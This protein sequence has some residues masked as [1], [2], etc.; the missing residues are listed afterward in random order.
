MNIKNIFKNKKAEKR[1]FS[2]ISPYSDS[3]LF[4]VHNLYNAMQ[5]SAAYRA[6]ELISDSVAMLP[7]I[8]QKTNKSGTVTLTNHA[9]CKVFDSRNNL[10]TRYQLLKNMLIDMLNKGNGFAL[11][12]RA[13]DGTPISLQYVDANDVQIFYNKYAGTVYYNYSA[14]RLTNRIEPSDMIH[15]FKNSVDG[16]NGISTLEFAKYSICNAQNTEKTANNYFSNGGNLSGILSVERPMS[17]EQ[18]ANLKSTW[19]QSFNGESGGIAVLDIGM[20]YQAV[21]ANSTDSQ[22]LESRKYNVEDIARFYGISPA[23]LGSSESTTQNGIEAIQLQFVAQT[24]QPY[25]TLARA[26]IYEKTLLK[27][28]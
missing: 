8:V 15:I 26:G 22:M 5:L 13:D 9:L 19:N 28:Q 6:V 25:I 3:L 17:N 4:G 18:K 10:M 12:N 16:V 23:L 14:N 21:Q 20:K 24:L 1:G 11:I 2:Y 27:L 7:V